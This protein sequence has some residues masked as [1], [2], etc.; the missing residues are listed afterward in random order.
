MNTITIIGGI[1]FLL[2]LVAAVIRSRRANPEQNSGEIHP[3]N[4]KKPKIERVEKTK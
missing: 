3:V 1:V 2:I 4:Y